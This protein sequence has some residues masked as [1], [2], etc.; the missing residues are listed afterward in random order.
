MS[1]RS[2]NH[3]IA[4]VDHEGYTVY[5]YERKERVPITWAELV[6]QRLALC[7]VPKCEA[8]PAYIYTYNYITGRAGRVSRQTRYLCA[9]H[10]EARAAKLGI[11]VEEVACERR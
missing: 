2:W 11:D 5:D 6:A 7:S 1:D 9:K 4:P 8:E 10:V 3:R